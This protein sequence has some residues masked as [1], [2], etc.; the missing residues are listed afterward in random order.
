MSIEGWSE[1]KVVKSNIA[2]VKAEMG[3]LDNMSVGIFSEPIMR[4]MSCMN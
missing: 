2:G 3:R 1:A 4:Q